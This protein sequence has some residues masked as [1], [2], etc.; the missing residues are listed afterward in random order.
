[1]KFTEKKETLPK[2]TLQI[3]VQVPWNE[4]E[5]A[6]EKAV[7]ELQKSFETEGFRK[8]KAPVAVVKEKMGQQRLLEEGA[9]QLLMDLY[10]DLLEKHAIKPY[11]D[12]KVDLLKAPLNGEWEIRFT[13]ALQPKL[14]KVPDYK[15]A[16]LKVHGEE[17][18]DAIWVPGKDAKKE[19]EKDKH[20]K[21]DDRLQKILDLVM[22]ETEL[23]ISDLIVDHE[24]N[25]RLASLHDEIAK[26]GMTVDQYLRARQETQDT[27]RAK[28]KKEVVDL[29]TLE[30]LLDAIAQEEKIEIGEK[31]LEAIYAQ[32][33]NEKDKEA[34][35][36]NAYFYSR[37][38][39][40][41]KTLD[42]LASL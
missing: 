18:K 35:K 3:T 32:A 31:E 39:R 4:V 6:Q 36:Q 2:Q 20:S 11:I 5:Q 1:M 22:K 16:A 13:V 19:E 41:Q 33:K 15:K 28:I 23:E 38:V 10:R 29:Y 40:K 7:V 17:K 26:L 9:Q 14:T 21:T 30:F 37:L 42:Y 8:G 25:R 34:M 27:L 12:P 24:L